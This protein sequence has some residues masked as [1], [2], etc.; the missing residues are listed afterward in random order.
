MSGGAGQSQMH[1]DVD[2]DPRR[3]QGLARQVAHLGAG[4]FEG[5]EL[6]HEPSRHRVPSPRRSRR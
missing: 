1:A 3:A 5:A 4:V 6:V 2:D